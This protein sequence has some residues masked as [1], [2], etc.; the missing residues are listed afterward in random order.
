MNTYEFIYQ[1]ID[2]TYLLDIM[3]DLYVYATL[4]KS[5]VDY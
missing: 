2:E 3:I 5:I 1:Y 4:I